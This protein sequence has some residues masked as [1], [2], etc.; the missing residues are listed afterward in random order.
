MEK[1]SN[2]LVVVVEMVIIVRVRR[3]R[4]ASAVAALLPNS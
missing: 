1:K 4:N 2:V 3:G